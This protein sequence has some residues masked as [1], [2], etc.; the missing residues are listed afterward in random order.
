MKRIIAFLLIAATLCCL[1]VSC[2]QPISEE[3]VE[4]DAVITDVRSRLRPAGKTFIRDRD[5]YFEY[6]GIVG[7]WDVCYKT[8]KAYKDKEGETI[9][10]YLIT[11]T[12]ED[13]STKTEL[14][15]K[16]DYDG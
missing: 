4:V 3:K 11:Y 1:L 10:C 8:Y 16:E 6:D 9:K 14:V 5:I 15:A 7:S 12:Y 2:A 13:G